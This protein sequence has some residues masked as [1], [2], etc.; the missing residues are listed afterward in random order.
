MNFANQNPLPFN[1]QQLL[2]ALETAAKQAKEVLPDAEQ[3]LE[4]AHNYLQILLANPQNSFSNEQLAT[5]L[6]QLLEEQGLPQTANLIRKKLALYL[7]QQQGHYSEKDLHQILSTFQGVSK[8]SDWQEFLN[9]F[10][11]TSLRKLINQGILLPA[12]NFPAEAPSEQFYQLADSLDDI[13]QKLQQTVL[14]QHHGISTTINFSALRPQHSFIST[15]PKTASG[16][17]TFLQIFQDTLSLLKTHQKKSACTVTLQLSVHHPDL[18]EFLLFLKNAHHHEQLR[19]NLLITADFLEAL[20]KKQNFS[21]S[22]PQDSSLTNQLDASETFELIVETTKLNPQLHLL[23]LRPEMPPSVQ[24]YA[25]NI[26]NLTALSDLNEILPILIQ[27]E[28]QSSVIKVYLDG[29]AE[30]LINQKISY[31]SLQT[32]EIIKELGQIISAF[33]QINIATNCNSFSSEIFKTTAGLEPLPYLVKTKVNLE[34]QENYF[35]HPILEKN[36]LSADIN[37]TELINKIKEQENLDAASWLPANL[38]QIFMLGGE[39]DPNWHFQIQ[40]QLEKFTK[41]P[42][43]KKIYLHQLITVEQLVKILKKQ[44]TQGILQIG[45]LEFVA[46]EIINYSPDSPQF[47]MK[48]SANR[49]RPSTELQPPLFAIKKTEEI[50]LPPITPQ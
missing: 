46:K 36:L 31:F 3:I 1:Q 28:A 33:P 29:F 43:D 8:I 15:S 14:N 27:N 6:A 50:T 41:T 35:F 44:L 24:S 47:L 20:S 38:Q 26:A 42:I 48:M 18:I 49:K 7:H 23:F 45:K 37:P 39:I 11:D 4:K 13:F 12:I 2:S 10:P 40:A 21:L 17:V 30:F 9:Q 5:L 34:G 16:P 32:L 22:N 19:Y 25:L